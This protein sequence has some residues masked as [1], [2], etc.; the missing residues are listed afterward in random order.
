MTHPRALN[1]RAL[2][3]R[4]LQTRAHEPRV[5]RRPSALQ[6]T[7]LATALAGCLFAASPQL[8]A[9][10][11]AATIRGQVVGDSAPAADAQVKATNV[12]TG[13]TRSVVA[14][15]GTY[16]LPGLVPGTYRID[17]TANGQTTSETVTVAVG[18][19]AT[20]NLGVGGVAETAAPGEAT[21]L[22]T[23]TVVAPPVLVE[24][25]TS[26]IATYVSSKQIEMLPQN[27]RNF[28]AFAE[29]VPG[30]LLDTS[31]N[32]QETQL[33]SGAQGSNAINVYIDGV[34]QK[35][36]VT[37]GGIAGQDD[38]EGN[39]FPQGAI[40]EYKVITS[41]YKAEY[42]QL[43]SAAV[44]AVTKSGTNDF[45]GSVF[46]DRTSESWRAP[47]PQ[48]DERGEKDEELVEQYG[49]TFGGPI[50]RD[51]LHFFLTYE[52]KDIVRPAPITAPNAVINTGYD[53]PSEITQ[54][55]GGA[56]RP[57]NQDVYFGKLSWQASEEH[58]LE[59]TAKVRKETGI[60]GIGGVNVPEH[61]TAL[62]NDDTRIDLRSQF[63]TMNWLNE[64]HVTYEKAAYNPS[65]VTPVPSARYTIVNPENPNQLDLQV[66]NLGGGGSFQDKGQAGAGVQNDLT[67][68][69]WEGHTIKM[70]VK[71]KVVDLKAFQQFPP[72]PRYWYDVDESLAQPYRVQFTAPRA[73]RDPFV[74][75]SN[76]QF[77]IY[78]QDDWEVNDKLTLNL[79]IRWDYEDNP[80]YTDYRLDPDIEAALRGWTNIQNTDYDIEDYI[81]GA[82]KRDNFKDAIQPRVGF[83]YD[84]FGDQRHVIFG[85]AGRAYDRNIFDVM[86]REY[87]GGAF[88]TYEINFPTDIHTCEPSASCIAFDPALLTPEGLEAYRAANPVA[89]GEVQL[90][91][92]N[93][94]TPYSDQYSLGMRNIVPLWGNDWNT[95]VTFQHIRARDGIYSHLGNRREDGS[96]HEYEDEG[97]SFGGAPFGFGIPNY[98]SLLLM[99]NGFAYDL[100]SLLLSADKPYTQSS[101]WGFNVA[102]TYSNA[103]ENRPN[104]S[105]GETYLF[106]YPFATNDFYTSTGVPEHQLVLSGIW[107]P[108]WDLTF[109]GKLVLRSHTPLSAVNRLGSPASGTCEPIT[110]SENCGDLNAYYAP[111]TPD[112]TIGYKRFDLAA[113]KRWTFGDRVG[114]KLR[115]DVIN[116]F[117]WRNWS[118]YNTNW[119]PAGGPQNPELGERSGNEIYVPTR[120]LKLSAGLDW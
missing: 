71:Y 15:N 36:Y 69:G 75:S 23:V 85:G 17:V 33:R 1:P 103:K 6:R 104:A 101:P 38:S 47:T 32:G 16:V 8:F 42:D 9:Q 95:S 48:E 100:N 90:L 96:F 25:K 3:P 92:N 58:L 113:E 10:S 106:D 43:S 94:K 22:D 5:R 52:A 89:G 67:F 117:N 63:S 86:A 102:Y 29:T 66:L 37:P 28:L 116:V 74:S 12:A 110:G 79:G 2:E 14:S 4:A 60:L 51:Q 46:W 97:Q 107:S 114:F 109:S 26:E 99:D 84:L 13:Q 87:Y 40:G 24:T 72:Y 108:G 64:A 111:V 115:A 44:T 105:N 61:G 34:G 65:P 70:G 27:S 88:T 19:T 56:S 91:N 54:Y 77:G 45:E 73:G 80:S 20:L 18:Q 76:T 68:F 82:G 83:S 55:Y 62:N 119:G 98:G 31:V 81:P 35:N 112:G 21:D 7:C 120:T 118:Q 59:L 57:F 30:M 93:L 11:T 53:L 78:F 49:A 39:P 50:L 41:N